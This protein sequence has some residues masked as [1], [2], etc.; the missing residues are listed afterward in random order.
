MAMSEI[1]GLAGQDK[2][3]RDPNGKWWSC[4]VKNRIVYDKKYIEQAKRQAADMYEQIQEELKGDN[5]QVYYALGL[6]KFRKNDWLLMFHPR[7]IK[8]PTNDWWVA[9]GTQNGNCKLGHMDENGRIW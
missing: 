7:G 8:A 5:A 3:F 9:Y 1:S 4:E 2:F 6:D